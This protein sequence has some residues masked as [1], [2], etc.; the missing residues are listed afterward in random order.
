MTSIRPCLWGCVAVL[1]LGALGI[2]VGRWVGH[3]GRAAPPLTEPLSQADGLRA[4]SSAGRGDAPSRCQAPPPAHGVSRTTV[5]LPLPA[6]QRPAADGAARAGHLQPSAQARAE[7]PALEQVPTSDPLSLVEQ[8]GTEFHPQGTQRPMEYGSDRINI[9]EHAPDLGWYNDPEQQ[10]P[11]HFGLSV[12]EGVHATLSFH[13]EHADSVTIDRVPV[14]PGQAYPIDSQ[15]Q[16]SAPYRVG[17]HLRT[18]SSAGG[19]SNN[20]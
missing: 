7:P 9:S 2:G 19:I 20:G 10:A 15:T 8:E 6:G 18:S 17:I 11:A 5:C 16:V 12:P 1:V 3:A 13:G 4:L 14:I